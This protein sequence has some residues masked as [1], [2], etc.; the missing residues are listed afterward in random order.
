MTAVAATATA[1]TAAI[2]TGAS[3]SIDDC[4]VVVVFVVD[5]YVHLN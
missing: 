4:H 1:A 5:L 2:V 3:L